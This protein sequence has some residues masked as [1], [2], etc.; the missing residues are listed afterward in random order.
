MQRDCSHA[1]CRNGPTMTSRLAN[2]SISL[3][4]VTAFKEIRWYMMRFAQVV[5]H[6]PCLLLALC[7][8][9]E[10]HCC[11]SVEISSSR[12]LVPAFDTVRDAFAW[13]PP[14]GRRA[15]N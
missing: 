6:V 5:Q 12:A 10:Y 1:A 13:L 15:R 14:S 2:R 11:R 4:L 3:K 8:L 9:M 7:L